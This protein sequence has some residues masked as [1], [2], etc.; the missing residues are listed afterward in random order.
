MASRVGYCGGSWASGACSEAAGGEELAKKCGLIG[1]MDKIGEDGDGAASWV[2]LCV[3]VGPLPTPS[4]QTMAVSAL[5][6]RSSRGAFPLLLAGAVW[7][8]TVSAVVLCVLDTA[9]WSRRHRWRS[10]GGDFFSRLGGKMETR[11]CRLW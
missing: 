3:Q 2:H 6:V 8:A 4:L 7:D 11:P 1:M 9:I 10:E 5:P